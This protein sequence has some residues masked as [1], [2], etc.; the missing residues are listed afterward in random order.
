MVDARVDDVDQDAAEVGAAG[1][2]SRCC[3]VV[4]GEGLAAAVEAL[5]GDGPA[6]QDLVLDGVVEGI[7]QS[8]DEVQR[9]AVADIV[10]GHRV[11]QMAHAVGIDLPVGFGVEGVEVEGLVGDATV[12]RI[13]HGLAVGVG[14]VDREAPGVGV[15]IGDRAAVVVG[16]GGVGVAGYTAKV[17][18]RLSG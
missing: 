2:G 5:T 14:Y 11:V 12:G 8:V 18:I 17:G 9:K 4:D 15:L 6:T 13:I 7:G 10:V 1:I 16:V 3:A